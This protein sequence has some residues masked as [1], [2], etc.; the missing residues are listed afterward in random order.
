MQMKKTMKK[1]VDAEPL[2]KDVT[3][4]HSPTDR[5]QNLHTTNLAAA[6]EAR[7]KQKILG[8]VITER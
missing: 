3:M 8:K 4:L 1:V 6:R 7:K 2:D 5:Q